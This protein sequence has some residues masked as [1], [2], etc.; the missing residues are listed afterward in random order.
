MSSSFDT[1][2][3]TGAVSD[4]LATFG[5]QVTYTPTSGDA[6]TPYGIFHEDE[7]QERDTPE[8]RELVRTGTLQISDDADLTTYLGIAS[9]AEDDTVTISSVDWHVSR[10]GEHNGGMYT[11]YL[12]RI[13]SVEKTQPGYR[14]EA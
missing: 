8:G 14:D 9:P 5:E 12:T 4:L 13:E 1:D 11:L 6:T 2:F 3:A 10:V 7:P